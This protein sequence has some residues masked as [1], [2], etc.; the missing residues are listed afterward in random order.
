MN[1]LELLDT[2]RTI[3]YNYVTNVYDY[4]G[5]EFIFTFKYIGQGVM[6]VYYNGL[7][8]TVDLDNYNDVDE[9]ELYDRIAYD[10]MR[11]YIIM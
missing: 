6:K 5:R 8:T 11:E 4:K 7:E 1:K 2:G 10:F 3:H 9:S